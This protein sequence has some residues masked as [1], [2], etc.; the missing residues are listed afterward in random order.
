M[1]PPP[2]RAHAHARTYAPHRT[3]PHRTA[4]HRTAPHRTHAPIH[5][6]PHTPG[7]AGSPLA[8]RFLVWFPARLFLSAE[9]PPS[10]RSSAGRRPIWTAC[11]I[12]IPCT[13]PAPG[14]SPAGVTTAGG[15]VSG[16]GRP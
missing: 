8:E 1:R 2:P 13:G 11:Q 15:K 9:S 16:K 7:S 6:P 14:Q 12:P 4:P 10:N 5:A 3:A